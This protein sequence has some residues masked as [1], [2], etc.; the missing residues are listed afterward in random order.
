MCI[1]LLWMLNGLLLDEGFEFA[2]M[3]IKYLNVEASNLGTVGS[4]VKPWK[5]WNYSPTDTGF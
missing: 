4:T 3:D 2:Y 1:M 5:L